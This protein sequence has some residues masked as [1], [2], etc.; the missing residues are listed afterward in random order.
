MCFTVIFKRDLTEKFSAQIN[1]IIGSYS[2]SG[3]ATSS[4]WKK[5]VE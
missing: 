5:T 3:V 4:Q 2:Y 1:L